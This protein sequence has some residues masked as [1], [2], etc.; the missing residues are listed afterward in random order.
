MAS[1]PLGWDAAT[2]SRC[3]GYLANPRVQ[4]S[5]EIEI[6]HGKRQ[7]FEATYRNLTGRDLFLS[8]AHRP[9]YVW[10]R[11]VSKYGIQ[12]RIYY[13]NVGV[14]PVEISE[15]T[16]RGRGVNAPL[17]IN[18]TE[19]V[20]HLFEHGFDF[21]QL[22]VNSIVA[23]VNSK[24]NLQHEFWQGYRSA[25]VDEDDPHLQLGESVG[26]PPWY[27]EVKYTRNRPTD[28][29]TYLLQYNDEPIW[30]VGYTKNLEERL[31]TINAHFPFEYTGECWRLRKYAVWRDAYHA[32]DMEQL[33][34]G[35]LTKYRGRRE[36]L[37][38]SFETIER[39]WEAAELTV[40]TKSKD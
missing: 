11:S 27:G 31:A 8:G 32:Y 10:G 23:C 21:G 24:Q 36:R 4:A 40:T 26:P 6:A 30:K 28:A 25:G 39:V 18:R 12:G 14:R 2:L 38:C 34:L 19:L 15:C 1:K 20:F 16:T 17:R 37:Q 3:I 22:D 7:E 5:I 13:Q 29:Y 33:V 35:N 9:Y